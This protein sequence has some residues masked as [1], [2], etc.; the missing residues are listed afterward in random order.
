MPTRMGWD[1]PL[2]C[3]M[4]YTV[5]L[6]TSWGLKVNNKCSSW[7]D[8]FLAMLNPEFKRPEG[9][10]CSLLMGTWLSWSNQ[11][12]H[13]PQCIF[14]LLGFIVFQT[15]P[16]CFHQSSLPKPSATFDWGFFPVLTMCGSAVN[17]FC[18]RRKRVTKLM[19]FWFLAKKLRVKLMHLH[20]SLSETPV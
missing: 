14:L 16:L 18:Q 5:I 7:I 15:M 3:S 1:W 6:R 9:F 12:F 4:H 11:L 10:T 13:C 19:C 2:Y 17:Y 20:T 8:C